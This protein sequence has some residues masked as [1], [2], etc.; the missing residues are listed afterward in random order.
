MDRVEVAM[1]EAALSDEGNLKGLSEA[2]R[3]AYVN[4]AMECARKEEIKKKRNTMN[5]W[6]PVCNP[7]Y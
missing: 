2:E 1:A 3:W 7:E 6:I 4:T 5:K